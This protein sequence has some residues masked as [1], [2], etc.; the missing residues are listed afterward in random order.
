MRGSGGFALQNDTNGIQ[1]EMADGAYIEITG[2]FSDANIQAFQYTTNRH[3]TWSVDGGS[4][5]TN[6]TFRTSTNIVPAAGRYINGA[7]FQNIGLGATLGI[8]TLK[9]A[10]VDQDFRP[11]AFEL[12]A[13]DTSSTANKSK[14]QIPSQSVVS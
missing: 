8:H 14:I 1:Y 12:I 11:Y 2:Y 6:T 7:G 5:T 3:F 4:G 9:I 10:T 13:Q